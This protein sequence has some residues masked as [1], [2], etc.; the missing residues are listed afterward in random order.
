MTDQELEDLEAQ[1]VKAMTICLLDGHMTLGAIDN[2][3]K[4][5]PATLKSMLE[6]VSAGYISGDVDQ[7]QA[8]MVMGLVPELDGVV[9]DMQEVIA[10]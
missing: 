2:L 1:D 8:G 5:F 4:N 9:K 3:R 10:P 7:K 6:N